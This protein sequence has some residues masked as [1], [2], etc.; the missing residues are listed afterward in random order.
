M[1]VRHVAV[2][3][4][5]LALAI[6]AA[7]QPIVTPGAAVSLVGGPF[8]VA[9]PGS[10][11]GSPALASPSSLVDGVA[12]PEN[13]DWNLGS[14]WWDRGAP[15]GISSFFDVFVEI[16]LGNVF[17]ISKVSM[18]ADNNDNYAIA[19]RATSVDPWQFLGYYA[20]CCTYGLTSRG[21]SP[22]TAFSAR[23]FALGAYDGD[24]YYSISEFGAY[25]T[26][27]VPEPSSIALLAT[28]LAGLGVVARRRRSR[29]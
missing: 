27:V 19:F 11:W 10:P 7:A 12:Q 23:Y 18:Q 13:Q 16:D 26:R 8:G 15:T 21:P 4:L 28:G 1:N 5:S 29:G 14:V 17:S 24:G 9:R 2:A 25:G 22:V 20:A 3:A 6:P